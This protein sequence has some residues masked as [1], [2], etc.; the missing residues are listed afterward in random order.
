MGMG[1]G[2]DR[3]KGVR[4]RMSV[5]SVLCLSLFESAM[6]GA[7]CIFPLVTPFTRPRFRALIDRRTSFCTR[8]D[9]VSNQNGN[10]SVSSSSSVS[11]STWV[12]ASG[13]RYVCGGGVLGLFLFRVAGVRSRGRGGVPPLVPKEMDE[14]PGSLGVR[15]VGEEVSLSR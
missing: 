9:M 15:T 1:I 3:V 7:V 4:W 5:S 12:S 13:V 10:M 11:A 6:R 14:V 8:R 2:V